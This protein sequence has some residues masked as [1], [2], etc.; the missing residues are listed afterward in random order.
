MTS[1]AA[2]SLRHAT[3]A[4]DRAVAYL[5]ALDE[6]SRLRGDVLLA[7]AGD[8][9]VAALSL[10]DGRTAADPFLRTAGAVAQLRATAR[11]ERRSRAAGRCFGA[12]RLRPRPPAPPRAP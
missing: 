9:P 5:S 7:L 10:A 2:L 12:P 1:S 4:D 8:R 3:P 11:R 6:T